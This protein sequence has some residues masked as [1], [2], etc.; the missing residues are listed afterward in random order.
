MLDWFINFV[1]IHEI[2]KDEDG[3]HLQIKQ[4]IMSSNKKAT[5]YPNTTL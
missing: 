5:K 3:A 1:S 4:K 2:I